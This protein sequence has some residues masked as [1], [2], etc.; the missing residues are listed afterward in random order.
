MM[1]LKSVPVIGK[2]AAHV[3]DYLLERKRK[4]YIDLAHEHRC[5]I[6]AEC[7]ERDFNQIKDRAL[8]QTRNTYYR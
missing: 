3:E 8:I 1:E 6:A 7:A 5:Y 4:R 2:V